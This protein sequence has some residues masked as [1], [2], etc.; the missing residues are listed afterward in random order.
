MVNTLRISHIQKQL[1]P[2]FSS[3]ENEGLFH[4][5]FKK[6]VIGRVDNSPYLFS[7]DFLMAGIVGL[8]LKG[9]R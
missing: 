6:R 5:Y 4:R 8:Y 3:I 2:V 9:T 7:K 1:L